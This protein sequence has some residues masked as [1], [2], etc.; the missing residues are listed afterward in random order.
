MLARCA[1]VRSDQAVKSAP[2]VALARPT[3]FAHTS[4]SVAIV[5]SPNFDLKTTQLKNVNATMV[6]TTTSFFQIH[7]SKA[8]LRSAQHEFAKT[9]SLTMFT[10][11]H[12]PQTSRSDLIKS[13]VRLAP[14]TKNF[15]GT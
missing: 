9:A 8:V 13:L 12:E 14:R 10:T 7:E 2:A 6:S 4:S 15:I 11:V 5:T 3:S 1:N